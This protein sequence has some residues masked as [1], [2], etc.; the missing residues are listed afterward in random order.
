M[1]RS[2][3]ARRPA[4][5]ARRGRRRRAAPAADAARGRNGARRARAHARSMST[6]SMSQLGEGAQRIADQVAGA[7]ADLQHASA[8][9]SAYAGAERH[10]PVVGRGE[11]ERP[12][13]VERRLV[14]ELPLE[15]VAVG[16]IAPAADL[17]HRQAAEARLARLEHAHAVGARRAARR[18]RKA[19]CRR[20]GRAPHAAAPAA[21]RRQRRARRAGS[22]G[23]SVGRDRSAG[24]SSSFGAGQSR[25]TGR[26]HTAAS[27]AC[28]PAAPSGARPA[29]HGTPAHRSPP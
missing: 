22:A 28:R 20:R 13:E 23:G 27:P 11:L 5:R 15:A 26:R 14:H 8:A 21:R 16:E 2:Q 4:P 9:R 1:T 17:D 25:R 24:R 18:S 7:D 19:P 3:R 29:G 12:V 6:A 10:Q